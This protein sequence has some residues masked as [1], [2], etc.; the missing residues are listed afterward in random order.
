MPDGN[1]PL[2]DLVSGTKRQRLIDTYIF[3]PL[4]TR[5]EIPP[6]A[7]LSQDPGLGPVT[8]KAMAKFA[9]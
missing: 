8:K 3:R 9:K 7:V 5:P 2:S 1:P 4:P 6:E